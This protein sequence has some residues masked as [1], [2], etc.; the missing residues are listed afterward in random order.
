MERRELRT[1]RGVLGGGLRHYRGRLG[2]E[3]ARLDGRIPPLGLLLLEPRRLARHYLSFLCL[4]HHQREGSVLR[5]LRVRRQQQVEVARRH[6]MQQPQWLAAALAAAV[7]AALGRPVG[8][9]LLAVL[10]PEH[11]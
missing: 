2:R 11:L 5:R 10:L 4:G 9:A 8:A 3:P 6:P 1:A 7:A